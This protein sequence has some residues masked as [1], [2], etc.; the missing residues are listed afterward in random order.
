[1]SEFAAAIAG[2]VSATTG[3]A[4]AMP[5]RHATGGEVTVEG[6][7]AKHVGTGQ[8]VVTDGI[9]EGK[10]IHARRWGEGTVESST[11]ESGVKIFHR[12]AMNT[13]LFWADEW[14]CAENEGNI[15]FNRKN[16]KQWEQFYVVGDIEKTFRLRCLRDHKM[17]Y[18]RN[19]RR[20]KHNDRNH[21]GT[22]FKIIACKK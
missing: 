8:I 13:Y 12:A 6:A 15:G 16:P 10:L 4:T 11:Y 3:V 20:L 18:V 14:L 1:M 17:V 19:D 9:H 5:W 22:S 7:N 2:G 21:P